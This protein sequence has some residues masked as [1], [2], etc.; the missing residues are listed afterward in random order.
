MGTP[1]RAR[2][3]IDVPFQ[4]YQK[5]KEDADKMDI[6]VQELILIKLTQDI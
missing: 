6:T 5:L 1:S 2:I 3:C 4:L